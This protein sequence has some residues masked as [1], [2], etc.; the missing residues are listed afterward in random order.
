MV[1]AMVKVGVSYLNDPKQVAAILVK[2]GKRA[3][4]EVVDAKGR[5]LVR[6]VRCPYLE[7][8]HPSCGCDKELLV[9]VNQPVVRF[10]QFND[11]S[12]D[13]SLWVYVRYYGAQFKTKTDM[14]MIMY[15]E[16]KKYDI[17]IPWP[18]RTVYQG[19]EKRE[20]E[21]IDKLSEKRKEVIDEYGIGDLGRG[22][23]E[24]E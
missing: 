14:R 22:S 6:Q 24:D 10:D 16:F 2:V 13:F 15:E 1:P 11:S 7:K 18:I 4:K 8:N 21:E 19:D 9:D 3:M 23:A 20:Q 5:H 12:L 17:R